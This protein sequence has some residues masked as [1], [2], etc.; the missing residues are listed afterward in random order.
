MASIAFAAPEVVT[1]YAATDASDVF[2][3]SAMAHEII[4]GRPPLGQLDFKEAAGSPFAPLAAVVERGLAAN[5]AE[6]PTAAKLAVALREAT[7]V[8]HGFE[9]PRPAAPYRGARAAPVTPAGP[10]PRSPAEASARKEQASSMSGIL[11][12]LLATGALFVFTGALWLVVVTWSTLDGPGRFLLLVMLTLGVLGSGVLLGRKDYGKSGA[13]LIVLGVELLWADGWYLLDVSSLVHSTGAWALLAGSMTALAFGL[14][15]YL[16]SEVFSVLAALH[17]MA[18]AIFF[19]VYVHS[20]TITGPLLYL[21]GVAA[22]AACLAGLGHRWRDH[23]GTPF[24]VLAA[25]ALAGSAFAGVTLIAREDHRLFGTVWPYAMAAVAGGCALMLRERSQVLAALVTGL[26]LATVPTIEAL[27][28]DNVPYL[29]TAVAI[30]FAVIAMAFT[31]SRLGREGGA[32]A[33]WVI[34]GLLGVVTG[35]SLQFLTKCWEKDGLDAFTSTE[36]VYLALVIGLAAALVALS[37]MLGGRATQKLNYR[38]LEL[39]GLSMIFGPF[40]LQ[41]IARCQDGFYPLVIL[42]VGAAC[43]VV[44]ATT[45]RAMLVVYGAVA[46]AVNLAIQ[47]FAKLWDHFPAA[48]LVLGFGLALLA[49]GVFYERRL[50]HLLPG[51]REW[52]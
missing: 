4:T 28:R 18:F 8:A 21:F 6:R 36:G 7:A 24:G 35:P 25:L 42:V 39:A 33:P 3:L 30:G 16:D 31:S 1:G 19:G 46:L 34:V 20:D 32:Q 5:P 17:Y 38:L 14:G 47:Y 9:I 41:S 27:M 50:K 13:A 23:L 22:C 51:L 12:I 15:G 26:I 44:G 52:A 45:K 11:M 49:G 2:A 37:Y 43:L 10:R 48:M 40:T 29:L